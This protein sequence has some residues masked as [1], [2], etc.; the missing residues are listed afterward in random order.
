MSVRMRGFSYELCLSSSAPNMSALVLI[1]ASFGAEPI[2]DHTGG[3]DLGELEQPL[4]FNLDEELDL[5]ERRRC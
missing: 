5:G 2:K 1:R 3:Y 4:S